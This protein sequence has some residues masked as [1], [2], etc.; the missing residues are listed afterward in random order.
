MGSGFGGTDLTGRTQ[1]PVLHGRRPRPYPHEP[2]RAAACRAASPTARRCTSASPKPTA[3]ILQEQQTVS[4]RHEDT[5]IKGRGR[6]D[7]CV[8][9]RAVPMVEAMAALVLADQALRHGAVTGGRF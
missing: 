4:R 9:P 5:T 7:P 1:R 3:T 6:H 8:L 2:Q